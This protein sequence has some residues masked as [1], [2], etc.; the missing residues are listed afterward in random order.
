MTNKNKCTNKNATCSLKKYCFCISNGLKFFPIFI[1]SPSGLNF[2]QTA[3]YI[4]IFSMCEI[5]ASHLKHFFI[6]IYFQGIRQGGS[7]IL[8]KTPLHPPGFYA[9]FL[10]FPKTYKPSLICCY[11]NL[12]HSTLF[13]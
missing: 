13:S 12:F 9:F 1:S 3:R 8:H 6:K 4:F 7:E 10:F 5:H 2:S 11:L